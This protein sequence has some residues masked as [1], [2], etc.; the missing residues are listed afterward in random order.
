MQHPQA[1]QACSLSLHGKERALFVEYF[2]GSR[3][4]EDT[5]RLNR[6]LR[7]LGSVI[8]L[9]YYKDFVFFKHLR[10]L[11]D[12]KEAAEIYRGCPSEPSQTVMAA[13]HTSLA[14][15]KKRKKPS[16]S[17][18]PSKEEDVAVKR[19]RLL[20]EKEDMLEGVENQINA[21]LQRAQAQLSQVGMLMNIKYKL[22]QELAQLKK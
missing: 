22:Q 4:V 14:L 7:A 21:G 19:Q 15:E 5:D 13:S 16:A 17:A 10:D 18:P 8:Q 2:N 9:V 3:T 20:S 12:P 1:S 11:Q 6:C